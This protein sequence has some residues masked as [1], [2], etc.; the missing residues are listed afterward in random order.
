LYLTPQEAKE[1]GLIDRVLESSE[2]LPKPL[3]AGVI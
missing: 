1:Y 2:E 3:P